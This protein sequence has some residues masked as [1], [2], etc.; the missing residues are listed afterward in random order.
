MGTKRFNILQAK[1]KDSDPWDKVQELIYFFFQDPWIACLVSGQMRQ[2]KEGALKTL[3][4][5]EIDKRLN[6][7]QA[8]EKAVLRC[9]LPS[10]TL[11]QVEHV[12]K[13]LD[14]VE[15]QPSYSRDDEAIQGARECGIVYLD[16]A[17]IS[18]RI[19]EVFAP[20]FGFGCDGAAIQ[21]VRIK[22]FIRN[23]LEEIKKEI[24]A[25][26]TGLESYTKVYHNKRVRQIHDNDI[27]KRVEME[28]GKR[29]THPVSDDDE[30]EDE[31]D[32]D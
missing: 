7:Y 10:L 1:L 24:P 20:E 16:R 28:D 25:I 8:F 23:A 19:V 21:T 4:C 11:S 3:V 29:F 17:K 14:F 13:I 18:L 31:D 9:E 2:G 27:H 30:D 26:R 6:E 15:D 5:D 32:S 12:G 22:D